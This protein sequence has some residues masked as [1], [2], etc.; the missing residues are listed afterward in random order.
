MNIKAVH[1][2][3]LLQD[4]DQYLYVRC[5]YHVVN[6]AGCVGRRFADVQ[7]TQAQAEWSGEVS[8]QTHDRVAGEK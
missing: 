3:S 7:E 2:S 1:I 8:E 6:R 5:D 4:Y